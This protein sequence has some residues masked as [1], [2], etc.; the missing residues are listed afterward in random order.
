MVPFQGIIL[1]AASGEERS[2]LI[3]K[4]SVAISVFTWSRLGKFLWNHRIAALY[5]HYIIRFLRIFRRIS[6]A[7]Y[8]VWWSFGAQEVIR[9]YFVVC[10]NLKNLL[11]TMHIF[12]VLIRKGI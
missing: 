8:G 4:G 7:I 6:T 12:T 11:H 2:P 5:Y 1:R 3:S 9:F 10:V